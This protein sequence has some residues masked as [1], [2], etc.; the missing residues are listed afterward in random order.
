MG[1]YNVAGRGETHA[2]IMNQT[3]KNW[4]EE[5]DNVVFISSEGTRIFF[6]KNIIV[7]YSSLLAKILADIPSTES[8]IFISLQLSEKLIRDLVKILVEGKTPVANKR[9]LAEI[10]AAGR[11]I[12]ITLDDLNIESLAETAIPAVNIKKE[13]IDDELF[14]VHS[15]EGKA[16]TSKPKQKPT[17]V[18]ATPKTV[19]AQQTVKK[20][21][22]QQVAKK[23]GSERKIVLSNKPTSKTVPT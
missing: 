21:R 13:V 4:L 7:L 16:K 11:A 1:L 23:A 9:Q 19:K 18:T 6:R 22:A 20:V 10:K 15:E 5:G 12:G 8:D 3:W 17:P 2:Q 14:P